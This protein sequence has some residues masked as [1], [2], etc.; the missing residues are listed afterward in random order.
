MNSNIVKEKSFAM[1]IFA[2][3][4]AS[5]LTI[6][7]IIIGEYIGLTNLNLLPLGGPS[8]ALWLYPV[9]FLLVYLILFFVFKLPKKYFWCFIILGVVVFIIFYI[10]TNGNLFVNPVPFGHGASLIH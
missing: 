3:V 10:I 4:L 5:C 8:W 7:L 6:I 9:Y 1:N 2:V